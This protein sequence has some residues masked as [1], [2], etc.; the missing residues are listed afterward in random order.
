MIAKKRS[1]VAK[2]KGV[3]YMPGND[4]F[5]ELSEKKFE[6]RIGLLESFILIF[7]LFAGVQLFVDYRESIS[8]AREQALKLFVQASRNV[9]LELENIQA[10]VSVVL[11]SAGAYREAKLF[12]AADLRSANA[13]F[14]PYMNQY[15]FITSINSGDAVGNGYLILND[16]KEWKN[17]IKRADEKGLVTWLTLGEKGKILSS[18][19]RSDDYDPRRRPWYRNS[20]M[21]ADIVWS[22]AYIF[23]TTRD[24]GITA[25]LRLSG[26]NGAGE[27]VGVDITLKDISHKLA[28]LAAG[29]KGMSAYLLDQEGTIVA[30]SEVKQFI[31]NLQ[32]RDASLAGI[33]LSRYPALKKAL[34]S[35]TADKTWGFTFEGR[36]FIA[37]REPVSF[38]PSSRY[39]LVLTAPENALAGNFAEAE[40]W[41]LSIVLLLL[42][43]AC[44][45]YFVRFL[46]PLRRI[47]AAIK[48]FGAGNSPTLNLSRGRNDEIGDLSSAFIQMT[49]ALAKKEESLTLQSVALQ[50]AANAI[51]ITDHDGRIEW[52]N[53]AFT[54]LTGYS[55]KEAIGKNPRDLVKSGVHDQAFYRHIWETLN[56]G[57]VWRGQMINQRKD[58]TQYTE[59]QTITPVKDAI[60]RTTHFIAIKRDLSE[61]AR[62]EEQL[63][64]SQKLE[65]VGTLAG[66][67]AHE[68]NNILTAIIGYGQI[69][70][71]KM[72]SDDPL[73]QNIESMLKGADR[74]ARLTKELLL[75]SRKQAADR[76]PVDLNEA[77]AR[78][79]KFL[80]KVIGED[81]AYRTDI[82]DGTIMVLADEY[83]LE[84]LL[85]NLATNAAHSMPR[86]GELRVTTGIF[87]MDAEFVSSSGFGKPGEYALLAV[88][89]CG[90][91]MN[92]ATQKRIFEP[93]FSTKEVGKGTGLGLSVV[94]GIISQHDGYISVSS[95]PEK[96]S[97]FKVY[98]PLIS[99]EKVAISSQEKGEEAAC[100]GG[101]E[102][103]LLA[104][105][106]E[107]V[108]EMTRGVLTEFGYS[109]IEAVDGADAVNKFYENRKTID[110]LLLDLIMPKMNG[111]E[112]FDKIRKIKPRI[113]VIFCSGYAPET[114]RQKA[115]LADN[116]RLI[117]KP[118]S[119]AELLREVRS[120]L[121]EER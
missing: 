70:L 90:E 110:L 96:G 9:Q 107:A 79:D 59:G 120:V 67:V 64:Q 73:R 62:L 11:Q 25:A 61:Q 39:S 88:T 68:F 46:I 22:D 31:S 98:L 100:V 3:I 49:D 102:T 44:V 69:T 104:E 95:E 14:I 26:E 24:V 113:K 2:Y 41:R 93:F 84:Q 116:A 20:I 105:D 115:S 45:W 80:S 92:E 63:R 81:I 106:D 101:K 32:E 109:V 38:S 50:A 47:V 74:A 35:R 17:R 56:S 28:A 58:G 114:I 10:A 121:D 89:D 37:L 99:T 16:G 87:S 36:E 111:K 43:V 6:F 12:D 29:I 60:G 66:G 71:M 53:P 91:G 108:R 54:A 75:F 51:I 33:G 27:V 57:E 23:R 4:P 42:T 8:S 78:V 48:E 103:I 117:A 82:H 18:E 76:K 118:S 97:V 119:P 55:S 7:L 34:Q 21:Q 52:I 85:V 5:K 86:G 13:L 94:Y 1:I 15:P 72:S 19:K 77:V 112:A 40:L 65:S 30:C 83:Q